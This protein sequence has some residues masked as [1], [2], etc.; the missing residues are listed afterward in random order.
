MRGRKLL[1]L[2]SAIA[3]LGLA[4]L[5]GAVAISAPIDMALTGEALGRGLNMGYNQYFLLQL[6]ARLAAR[7]VVA[8][9]ERLRLE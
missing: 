8:D 9:D 3:A 2:A 6:R 5:A 1:A 4:A 7:H